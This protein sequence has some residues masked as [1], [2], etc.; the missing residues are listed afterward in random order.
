MLSPRRSLTAALLALGSGGGIRDQ[1]DPA[2]QREGDHGPANPVR[3][4]HRCI[5]L[6]IP[7]RLEP[8]DSDPARGGSV[9]T[10]WARAR[11]GPAGRPG[12]ASASAPAPRIR[13]LRVEDAQGELDAQPR[14]GVVW[15]VPLAMVI[16]PGSGHPT[17]FETAATLAI[18]A[19]TVGLAV[20]ASL[21]EERPR[22]EL[23]ARAEAA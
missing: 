7:A 11:V 19:L 14:L 17:P 9:Y 15:F 5:P 4:T 2:Q 1:R 22:V 18:A 3:K 16:T 20:R 12:R 10:E 23:R 21:R 6:F 8:A 13:A